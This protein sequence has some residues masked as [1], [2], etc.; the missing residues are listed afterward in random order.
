MGGGDGFGWGVVGGN[1][2]GEEMGGRVGDGVGG[3]ERCGVLVLWWLWWV[4]CGLWVGFL[5][6]REE[7]NELVS[8]CCVGRTLRKDGWMGRAVLDYCSGS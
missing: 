2:V 6:G 4:L 1:G 5:V 8:A 7:V 3:R